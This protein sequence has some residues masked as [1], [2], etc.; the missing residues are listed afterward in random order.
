LE[1]HDDAVNTSVKRGAYQAQQQWLVTGK[2]LRYTTEIGGIH[3]G[4][5]LLSFSMENSIR[6]LILEDSEADAELIERELQ[7]AKIEFLAKHAETR[8]AFL[9]EINHFKPDIVLSD[10]SMAGF[11]AKDA[12]ELLKQFAPSVPLIVV[13]GSIDDQKAA[14]IVHMGAANYVTKGHLFRIVPALIDALTKKRLREERERA[15]DRLQ[16]SEQQYRLLFDANPQPMWVYDVETLAFLNVNRA[17]VEQYGYTVQEFLSMTVKDIRPKEE[18]SFFLDYLSKRRSELDTSSGWRHR[19]K[20]GTIIDVDVYS[21]AIL[22]EG[23]AARL[24][25]T[26]DIT[27]RK[28]KDAALK[29]SE[30]RYREILEKMQ[31]IAVTLDTFGAITFCNSF[32]LQLTGWNAEEI[33]QKNWFDFFLPEDSREMIR[34]AFTD[35]INRGVINV[36]RENDIVTKS[37]STASGRQQVQG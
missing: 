19:K 11:T 16:Q 10:Y 36:H 5:P 32:L 7:K 8:T 22:Y 21:N 1:L 12:M 24:V 15:A 31:L 13:S 37:G 28:R 6:I 26:R 27:E 3:T 18:V 14:E 2:H 25:A 17:A 23:N 34:E 20:D 29:E 9:R 33:I 35:S 4:M 30:R